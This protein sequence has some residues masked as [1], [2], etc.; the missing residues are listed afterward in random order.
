MEDKRQMLIIKDNLKFIKAVL[1]A[2]GRVSLKIVYT[3]QIPNRPMSEKLK[4]ND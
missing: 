2:K 4:L 3:K 1:R